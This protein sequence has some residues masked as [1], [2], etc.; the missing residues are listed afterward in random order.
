MCQLKIPTTVLVTLVLLTVLAG[1]KPVLA[2]NIFAYPT[3]IAS[4]QSLYPP[5]PRLKFKS[6]GQV[7]IISQLEDARTHLKKQLPWSLPDKNTSNTRG[8]IKR[9]DET[10]PSTSQTTDNVQVCFLLKF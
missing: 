4:K 6:N 3:T 5:L 8:P 9:E 10:T 1:D 7:R 2:A